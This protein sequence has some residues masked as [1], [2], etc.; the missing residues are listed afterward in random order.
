MAEVDGWRMRVYWRRRSFSTNQRLD[1]DHL[2]TISRVGY[3]RLKDQDPPTYST[4]QNSTI[5]CMGRG[6]S[7]QPV[8]SDKCGAKACMLGRQSAGVSLAIRRT[9]EDEITS[10]PANQEI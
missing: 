9:V 7:H 2:V 5:Y 1:A 8:I 4:V 10:Q 3:Q 6:E